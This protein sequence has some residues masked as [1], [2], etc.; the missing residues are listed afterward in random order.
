ML[1]Y[2]GPAGT[3]SS[4]AA[5]KYLQTQKLR[6]ESLP[7]RTIGEVIDGV[8]SGA[9][10]YGLVPI[11]NML[12]GGVDVTLDMLARKKTRLFIIAEIDIAVKHKLIAL[13]G[14]KLEE[15]R[16][17]F[18]H[19]QALAQC[20]RYLR[21][22]FPR[23]GVLSVSS[24]AE[25]VW[26]LRKENLRAAAA[27]GSLES[28]AK[29]GLKVLAGDIADHRDNLTRFVVLAKE[30]QI[31]RDKAVTSCVFSIRK[32]QP[33]GLYNILRFL[34]VA[35]INM[36]KIESRPSKAVMGDYIFFVDFDGTPAGKKA[37][38]ALQDMQNHCDFFKL[39]G[40]YQRS[41]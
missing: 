28:A 40:V 24:T 22:K 30:L 31:P 20:Q 11:E 39:L 18:S 10:K 4:Q 14:V 41:R 19:P 6:L 21:K 34:A 27:I 12:E 3:Y 16:E 29:Y 8:N 17:I 9:Y 25:A 33:G 26:K 35:R 5:A 13:P 37:A 7:L 38:K 2:L 36:T 15:V 1:A 23:A 32:D